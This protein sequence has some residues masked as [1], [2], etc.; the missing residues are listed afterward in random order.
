MVG[1]RT[2]CWKGTNTAVRRAHGAPTHTGVITHSL[3]PPQL[4]L[5]SPSELLLV[6]VVWVWGVWADQEQ[7]LWLQQAARGQQGGDTEPPPQHT[8]HP[9]TPCPSLH[10]GN[11]GAMRAL[12]GTWGWLGN[13]LMSH[14]NATPCLDTALCPTVGGQNPSHAHTSTAK[15]WG[16]DSALWGAQSPTGAPKTAQGWAGGGIPP[17]GNRLPFIPPRTEGPFRA[18]GAPSKAGHCGADKGSL[19]QDLGDR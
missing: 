12:Q 9:D 13:A 7:Q 11:N 5:H 10:W 6:A 16:M 14:I 1:R 18:A 17:V 3:S 15:H 8:P 19:L 2:P 4:P